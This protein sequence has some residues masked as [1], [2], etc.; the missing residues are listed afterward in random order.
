MVEDARASIGCLQETKLDAVT[1][2]LMLFMM[3]IQF[4][5]FA[6]LPAN[7]TCGGVIIAAKQSISLSD[8]HIGCFSLTVKV[9]VENTMPQWWLTSVYGPQP[10]GQKDLFLE[11]LAAIKDSCPGPWLIIGDFNLILS[12]ADK[13]NQHINRR[14]LQNFRRTVDELELQDLHLHGRVY[15]WSNE[16]DNPTLVKLDRALASLDWEEQFPSCHL[17]ALSSD[18]SDHCPLLLQTNVIP[19]AKPRFHFEIFWPKFEGYMEAVESGWKCPDSVT[20]PYKRLDNL[21]RNTIKQL[22]SWAAKRIGQIKTQL[23]AAREIILKLDQAQEQRQLSEDEVALRRRLKHRCL[24]LASL[25]RTIARQRSRV[26]QLR[27][28]DA[29]TKFFH[30]MARGRKRKNHIAS[31]VHGSHTAYLQHDIEEV[32]CNHFADIF[33]RE[34]VRRSRLNLENLGLSTTE[35][36]T[37]DLPFTEDEVW[38]AIRDLSADK[39]PGPDGFTG[40]F[41]QSAWPIIKDDILRALNAFYHTDGRNFTLLNNAFIVLLPKKPD[42]KEAKDYRPITLVHSF[43]KLVSKLMATRL[44]PQLKNLVA[45]N[46]NAFIKGRSIH[47][48]YKFIQRAAVLLKRRKIPKML[49]KLDISKAFDTV[50]W[51]FLIEV[52][53][54]V[55]FS[56]RWCNWISILMATATS[57]ILVNGRPGRPIQ[58]RRGVRQGDP[59]SPMLFILVMEI[60]H[61]LFL[62]ATEA[63]IIQKLEVPVIKYQCSIYADDAIIFARPT[64][65]EARAINRL[66]EIFGDASGLRT[67]LAKC[68]ITPIFADDTAL[69]EVQHILGCQ[70]ASFPIK[71]LGLPLST[72]SLP[73]SGWQPLVESVANK[74]P[75]R[76]GSLMA[77]SGRLIWVKSVMSAVPIYAMLAEKMPAWVREEIESICRKFF[78]AGKDSSIRGKCMVNWPTLARPTELGGLGVLDLKLFGYALQTRWLWLQKTDNDRAWAQLPIQVDPVVLAFFRASTTITVGSGRTTL[79]WVDN[80]L[81][82]QA[83]SDLAPTLFAAV[84]KRVT[85]KLTVAEAMQNRQW[86]RGIQGGLSVMAIAEYLRLWLRLDNVHLQPHQDDQCIWRWTNNGQ[87]SAKSAYLMLHQGSATFPGHKLIWQTW[88]PLKVKIFLWLAFR[89]RHWTADRRARH[90]LETHTNCPLCDQEPET[91]DHLFASCT[92]TLQVW[93]AIFATLGVDLSLPRVVCSIR[94]R[95]Q[96]FRMLL[97][98]SLQKGFDTLFA[99]VCWWI[100][101]ERNGRIFRAQVS[102][103]PQMLLS[104]KSEAEI[105]VLAGAKRLGCLFPE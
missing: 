100:W 21:F 32:I 59:L 93:F 45:F 30:L 7:G 24:G 74:L 90:G 13:N 64:Q 60:L 104:I 105:W 6:Y 71:Y 57:R 56:T 15:T 48:N 87:Y 94:E 49:L 34:E 81:D 22:Q 27:D 61:Q 89:Q 85:S 73:K 51:A 75:S 80:W 77:R 12:A 88:A 11:E 47:D 8:I 18:A 50:S 5:E 46:Q 79:F 95:W 55:G 43:A 96:E 20:D 10:D 103:I 53:R 33:G 92:V 42:A 44:A 72:K 76:H 91:S 70:L 63:G 16:R 98:G 68:S 40:A 36:S 62:K 84:S 9:K 86:V 14:N 23:L 31:I 41:Y 29:N 25:E 102:T 4:R 1:D 35:L 67:N 99:L 82:G 78:W 97:P 52:L 39:A 66:L 69:A 83:I 28:G 3:G 65:Q 58:H 2:G 37:L 54:A 19:A 26:L 38:A 101:K 17:Q